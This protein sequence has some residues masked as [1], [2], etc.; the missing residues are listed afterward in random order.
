[1]CLSSP[2]TR[3]PV[4]F[5]TSISPTGPSFCSSPDVLGTS[6]KSYKWSI[7][8]TLLSTGVSCVRYNFYYRSRK[9][10][11]YFCI[12][13]LSIRFSVVNN[14]SENCYVLTIRNTVETFHSLSWKMF[15]S[16]SGSSCDSFEGTQRIVI[17][18]LGSKLGFPK[19]KVL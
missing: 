5:S 18:R 11:N 7:T 14:F 4:F 13:L 8:R 10:K 19:T 12:V 6:T 15:T 1:M 9:V 2:K 16:L 3:Y 17:L